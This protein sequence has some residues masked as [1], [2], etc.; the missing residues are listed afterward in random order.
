MPIKDPY[1]YYRIPSQVVRQR[2]PHGDSMIRF[3]AGNL[4]QSYRGLITHSQ[5]GG[6]VNVLV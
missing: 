4:P 3:R 6:R 5:T 1:L 2:T